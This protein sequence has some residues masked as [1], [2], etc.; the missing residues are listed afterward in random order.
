M[1]FTTGLFFSKANNTVTILLITWPFVL[2]HTYVHKTH[3]SPASHPWRRVSRW[4]VCCY[5]KRHWFTPLY[6]YRDLRDVILS[7]YEY[8]HRKLAVG[9]PN[10]FSAHV[11]SI[12][13]GVEWVK[14]YLKNWEWWITYT[15]IVATRLRGFFC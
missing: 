11:P 13:A 15:G 3:D 5:L 1:V 6:I 7:A 12:E 10:A 2:G 8:G 4:L 14:R 9:R